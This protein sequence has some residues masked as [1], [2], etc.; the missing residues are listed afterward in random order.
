ME[1]LL[2]RLP[3]VREIG[4]ERVD[5][6]AAKALPRIFNAWKLDNDDA[7]DLL[8]VGSRT[9]QRMKAHNWVGSLDEDQRVRASAIV[10][11]Y[12]ALHVYFSDELAD[13]WI[14]LPNKGSPFEGRTPIAFLREGG[15]PALLFV[16][17]FLDALRG[18]A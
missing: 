9:Y 13:R 6:A 14:K 18:G 7:A 4:N 11:I 8:R 12:K 1:A 5:A 15:I 10:G 2:E 3:D 16:R 17:Q